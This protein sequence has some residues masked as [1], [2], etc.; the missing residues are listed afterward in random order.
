MQRVQANRTVVEPA[1]LTS[2][3]VLI[4]WSDEMLHLS[5]YQL[6]CIRMG[7]QRRQRLQL[8]LQTIGLRL[9]LRSLRV[10]CHEVRRREV[11]LPLTAESH[12]KPHAHHPHCDG[13]QC[14]QTGLHGGGRTGEQSRGEDDRGLRVAVVNSE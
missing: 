14:N 1:R 12:E 7:R 8:L 5:V 6:L 11:R 2:V 3:A 9:R 13:N 4:L 10:V